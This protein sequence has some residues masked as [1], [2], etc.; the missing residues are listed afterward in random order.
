MRRS[1]ADSRVS[2][3]LVTPL[4]LI[5]AALGAPLGLTLAPPLRW[6]QAPRAVAGRGRL[7]VTSRPSQ[8][9]GGRVAVAGSQLIGRRLLLRR[10]PGLARAGAGTGAVRGGEV[11]W[12]TSVTWW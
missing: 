1:T 4:P 7:A 5:A 9:I 8:L 10:T 2:F 3:C 12:R 6:H 11:R